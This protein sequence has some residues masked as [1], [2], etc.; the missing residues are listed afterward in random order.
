MPTG[1][2]CQSPALQNKAYCYYHQKLYVPHRRGV[3]RD[4]SLGAIHDKRGI[5]AA[6]SQILAALNK[7]YVD[8]R[9]AGLM[10]YGLQLAM[11]AA[12]RVPDQDASQSVRTIGT[13]SGK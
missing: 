11:Q 13:R 8:T 3:R 12:A 5:Q 1:K 7:P 9:R 6:L 10:L 4:I 2:T